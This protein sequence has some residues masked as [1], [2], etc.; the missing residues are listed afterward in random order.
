[1]GEESAEVKV[2]PP[3]LAVK[4]REEEVVRLRIAGEDVYVWWKRRAG[5]VRL[6]ICADRRVE[7]LRMPAGFDVGDIGG[8]LQS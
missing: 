5:D 3:I 6:Y 2:R 7:I 4:R 1:M 8:A